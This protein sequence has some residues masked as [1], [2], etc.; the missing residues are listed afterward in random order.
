MP[1]LEPKAQEPEKVAKAMDAGDIDVYEPYA[2]RPANRKDT[3]WAGLSSKK[4]ST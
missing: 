1:V 3:S 2:E 4:W